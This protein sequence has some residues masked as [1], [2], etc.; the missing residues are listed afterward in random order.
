[1]P[2][3][4]VLKAISCA[5]CVSHATETLADCAVIDQLDRLHSLQAQFAI[6]P[7]ATVYPSDLRFLRNQSQSLSERQ[8]LDAIGAPGFSAQGASFSRFL[9]DTKRITQIMARGDLEK[10]ERHYSSATVREAI[11]SVGRFLPDLI[12]HSAFDHA[13]GGTTIESSGARA[14][15]STEDN[16]VQLLRHAAKQVTK[17]TTLLS[18]AFAATSVIIG[19]R[20]WQSYKQWKGRRAHRF[21]ANYATSLTIDAKQHDSMVI[22]ISAKGAKLSFEQ[23]TPLGAKD[24][25]KI[26]LDDRAVPAKVVWCNTHYVGVAFR[27]TIPLSL[28]ATLRLNLEDETQEFA[29]EQENGAA[30]GAAS[31]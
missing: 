14:S 22:D 16:A 8:M 21:P 7:S 1:M 4:Q 27:R 31:A 17:P 9:R 20:F 25:I 23:E 26:F 28:V 12:C 13:K 24:R 30:T 15:G 6:N 29:P 5:I 2:T 3:K 10:F 19:R 11:Q 18:L